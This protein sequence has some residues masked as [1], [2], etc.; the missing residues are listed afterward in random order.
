MKSSID[1]SSGRSMSGANTV[2][3][4]EN[5]RPQKVVTKFSVMR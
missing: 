5:I 3:A 1:R 2:A 4:A